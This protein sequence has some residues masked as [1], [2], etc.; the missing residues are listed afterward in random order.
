MSE[1][2][3][4]NEGVR[5]ILIK[6]AHKNTVEESLNEILKNEINRK[7]KKYM[8]MQKHFEKK[9]GTDYPSFEASLRG[10]EP[11]FEMEKDYL[12]WDMAVTVVEDLNKE[13][14]LLD[15]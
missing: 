12:D 7:I 5:D 10:K 8:I 6:H 11:A 15:N 4:V 1:M 2:I 14:Q 9:Y 3:S 13:L